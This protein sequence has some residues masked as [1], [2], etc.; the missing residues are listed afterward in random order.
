MRFLFLIFQSL[1]LVSAT[2]V[3]FSKN[4]VHS[5]LFLILV[6]CNGSAILLLLG[7]EFLSVI[8][9]VVYVG[10]IAVLFLFIVMMLN[11]KLV[12]FRQSLLN[13]YPVSFIFI[14]IFIVEFLFA[15]YDGPGWLASNTFPLFVEWPQ[16]Y[17]SRTNI[18][19]LGSLFYTYY[20][21]P[22]LLSGVILLVAMIGSILLTFSKREGER[23]QL[24]F[25]QIV[26]SSDLYRF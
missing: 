14:A 4:P 10:A 13:H 25:D 9:L 3:L 8:F 23:R 1:L 26:R 15:L 2:L 19:L 16:V 17:L 6:F 5:V 24:I 21:F 7:M 11:L 20:Y 18:V 22:F 12:E